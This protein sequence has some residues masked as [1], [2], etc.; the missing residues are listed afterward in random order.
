MELLTATQTATEQLGGRVTGYAEQVLRALTRLSVQQ[1]ELAASMTQMAAAFRRQ[2]AQ[3]DELRR[4][5][6]AARRRAI[7]AERES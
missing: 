2:E 5:Y 6:L 4:E 3:I 1:E 7:R